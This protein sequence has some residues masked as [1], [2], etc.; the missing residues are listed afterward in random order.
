MRALLL[1]PVRAVWIQPAGRVW[2][3]P[4]NHEPP[5]PTTHTALWTTLTWQESCLKWS[6]L[7]LLPL[8]LMYAA[9]R[10]CLPDEGQSLLAQ[11]GCHT[12]SHE[13]LPTPL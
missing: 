9:L 6:L 2:G 5:L 1:L 4:I 11:V 12:H 10:A 7:W 3:E 8:A 13:T